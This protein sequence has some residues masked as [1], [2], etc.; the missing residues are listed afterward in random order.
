ME[1]LIAALRIEIRSLTPMSI[2]IALGIIPV[3]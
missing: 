2:I 3:T 1:G